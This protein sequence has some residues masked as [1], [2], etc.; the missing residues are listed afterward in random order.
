MIERIELPTPPPDRV[1]LTGFGSLWFDSM[2]ECQAY[3]AEP[4]WRRVLGLTAYH[5][6][7]RKRD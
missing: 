2:A 1:E 3:K 5:I 6:K 4:F 7:M